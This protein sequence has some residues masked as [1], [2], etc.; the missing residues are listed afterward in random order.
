MKRKSYNH[1]SYKHVIQ[2]AYKWWKDGENNLFNCV[3]TS[4]DMKVIDDF[5]A[6]M[7]ITHEELGLKKYTTVL[8]TPRDCLND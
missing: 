3:K 4:Y 8:N 2:R 5:L 6:D 1:T 7:N